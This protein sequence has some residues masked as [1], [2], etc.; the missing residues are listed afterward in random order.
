LAGDRHF[1]DKHFRAFHAA[2]SLVDAGAAL[3]PGYVPRQEKL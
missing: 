2:N 3:P 1:I